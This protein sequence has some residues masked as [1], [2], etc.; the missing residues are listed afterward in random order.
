MLSERLGWPIVCAPFSFVPFS[1]ASEPSTRIVFGDASR[2]ATLRAAYL[3]TCRALVA[4]TNNDVTN[5]EA[6]LQGRAM[7]QDLRV[8]LRLFDSDLAERVQR[9]FGITISRSVPNLAAPAFAAAML[10][11]EVLGTISVDRMVLLIAE[12]P[13]QVGSELDGLAS[14]AVNA[15]HQV[16]VIGIQRHGSDALELPAPPDHLLASGDRLIILA[17]RA[18]L[19]RVLIRSVAT[20]L[21][22]QLDEAGSAPPA[23]GR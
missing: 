12:I 9:N 18:G 21:W 13:I 3:G 15:P 7:S 22:Q 17:T 6:A 1:R 16:Q 4:V 19:G 10:R 11:R 8:V 23:T 2:E 20:E 5:L 14:H